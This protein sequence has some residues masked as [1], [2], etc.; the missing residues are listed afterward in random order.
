MQSMRAAIM[1]VR[2]RAASLCRQLG[3]QDVDKAVARLGEEG[4][5]VQLVLRA[6]PHKVYMQGG[7]GA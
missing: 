3:V 7:S 5:P 4:G 2:L 1:A 6:E